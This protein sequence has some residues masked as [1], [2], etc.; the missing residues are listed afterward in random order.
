MTILVIHNHYTLQGGEDEVVR[1]EEVMLRHYGHKVV[2]YTRS[3]SEIR[4]FSFIKKLK[5]FLLDIFWSRESYNT[6]RRIIRREKPDIVHV[7]NTFFLISPSIYDACKDE[8]VPVVQTLH[9][10]RLLCPI[11]IFYRQGRI[12]QDCLSYGLKS[13][14]INKCWQGSRVATLFLA[15]L[16]KIIRLRIFFE[17]VKCY[18]VLGEFSRKIYTLNGVPEEKV[19]IKSN[20]LEFDPGVSFSEGKYG[21]FIGTLQEYKGIRTLINAWRD[22]DGDF[23]LKIIGEGPLRVELEKAT[24]GNNIEFLGQ[25]SLS[26]VLDYI[27]KALFVIVPS[28]CYETGV[29][30]IIESFACGVPLVA[31]DH[32]AMKELITDHKTGLLFTPKDSRDLTAKINYLIN[33]R[34]ATKKMGFNARKEFEV[35]YTEEKNYNY[36]INIYRSIMKNSNVD[37]YCGATHNQ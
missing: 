18:I 2:L 25:K 22:V 34:D 8:N 21:L 5:T 19:S 26:E 14:V 27:K 10:Y 35:K 31:S 33:N 16:I 30:V 29:R 23:P 36:L 15:I 20:F 17:K 6:V 7:H 24:Q 11:G 9:N 37:E 28:E 32:G 3:N 1:S 4:T 12:C 13:A